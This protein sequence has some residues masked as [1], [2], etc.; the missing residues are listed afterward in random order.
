MELQRKFWLAH[1]GQASN[2]KQTSERSNNSRTKKQIERRTG[3][4]GEVVSF[5]IDVFRDYN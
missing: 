4:E 3:I 5:L 1:L 2:G